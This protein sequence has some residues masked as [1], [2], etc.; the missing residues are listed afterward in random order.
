MPWVN[1]IKREKNSS[2]FSNQKHMSKN[3]WNERCVNGNMAKLHAVSVKSPRRRI[4]QKK[5]TLLSCH[6][7]TMGKQLIFYHHNIQILMFFFLISDFSQT[8][9]ALNWSKLIARAQPWIWVFPQTIAVKRKDKPK[10]SS[11]DFFPLV[12]Y[13]TL[14]KTKHGKMELNKKHKL[15]HKKPLISIVEPLI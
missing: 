14:A 6:R 2:L 10:P 3:L 15:K 9:T 5:N 7:S 1:I 4:T 11:F 12:E 8:F 13:Q